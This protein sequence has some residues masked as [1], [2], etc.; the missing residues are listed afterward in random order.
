L[1]ILVLDLET[2]VERIEGRIDN[3]P[4]NPRN[5]CV[6]GY[7]G[8]LGEDTVDHVKKAVWYHK[9]Y[10]GCDPTD[11][12]RADLLSADM[13][14]CHNTK[15]D[16]EW[17][18]EMGFTLP[19]IVYDTMIV[20]YLLAKGQR[21]PLSLKESAIRRQVKSL[22]KSELIDE[23]F[24]DGV[25]FS[26]MPLEVVNEYAEAD[27]K[28]CGELYLAQLPILEREHNQSL[29]KVIPFMHEMLLFLCE[30]EMNG[31]K[32]DLDALEEVERE[33]ES[34]KE[35][36][37]KRLN[38]IVE[39]V[40]GDTP[41]NLN[42]G[43][44]MTKVVYSREVIS[45]E[46]HQQTFNIGTNEAGKS[47][48]PPFMTQSQ[49]V[50][51]VRATTKIVHKTRAIKC[52]D[53]NG[54]GSIQK[55]KVKT[56]IKLGK[57]YRVQTDEPY[58]NRTKCKTCTGA[59]AIYQSTGVAAGLRMS[60]STAFDASI[61][62]FKTDKETI[63]GLILQAERKKNDIAVEFLTKISRL[64]ALSV[65]LDSFVAGIQR[66]TRNTGF[67]HANFNQCVAATGRLSSGGGMSINLQNQPKRGFP[68][69]KC[70]I[71]RFENGIW[72]ESDYSGLEFRTACELSRDSQGLA[73]I[74]EGK[75][76]HRQTASICLKKPASHVT[77]DERQG[78]KWASFQPLF[79]GTGFGMPDHIKAYFDRFYGIY[80]GIYGWHQ[81]LM[82]GTL[83]NGTVETPSGRQY[84]WP[85][86][87]RTKNGRVTSATQILNYP[88]QGFSAD[89][90]Q[91]AC[92][93]A[94]KLFKQADLRS[95]LTLTVHDSIC[96][97]TH[98]DEIEQ[99]KSIL[100]EAMT[101]VGEEA[102]KRFGYKTIV[103]L[104]IEISGGPNWLEQQ[105]YA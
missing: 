67:L 53:C 89:L 91:L 56:K 11:E 94:F 21:R 85:N 68:V 54:M 23:M 92:I 2:T 12:L 16:A 52:H 102:E 105:E 93:R 88:V 29:K 42:S 24:R 57:K 35:I 83:K 20:E 59:G 71:S 51:A 73:D 97:D 66:G 4:K 46:A 64:S 74:L 41:I 72:I 50:D 34:E 33:F 101:G 39:M 70:F 99:V 55:Y 1:K 43:A 87:E 15:F 78:H 49:F 30:I 40:M 98:P 80:E 31:V 6:S 3:S 25:D 47:L 8:W 22:K 61:N 38:E 27:V 84:F 14:V 45:R 17:L 18:Q 60:P 28:A 69:R 96:V 62:G 100:T 37:E 58:K 7:W 104:D 26:E 13:M 81:S 10:E 44:D 9:D 32:V 103:P 65:Y 95:K 82:T 75:D 19:P 79:G 5:K 36:L 63:K 90:V 48:R 77:K 86:V 76:I